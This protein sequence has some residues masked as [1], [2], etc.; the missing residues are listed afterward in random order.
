[1]NSCLVEGMLSLINISSCL[2]NL[3]I[4][5]R[6]FVFLFLMNE[7]KADMAMSNKLGMWKYADEEEDDN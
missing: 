4:G 3:L 7:F 1:M 6:R 5:K 2:I